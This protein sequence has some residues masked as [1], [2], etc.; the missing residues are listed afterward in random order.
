V[1]NAFRYGL[2]EK[3]GCFQERLF[4][5][6]TITTLYCVFELPQRGPKGGFNSYISTFPLYALPM[7]LNR[8]LMCSQ[9]ITSSTARDNRNQWAFIIYRTELIYTIS[10]ILSSGFLLANQMFLQFDIIGI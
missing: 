1:K 8:R 6:F 2:V 9:V 4:S 5:F 3:G 10:P 7:P